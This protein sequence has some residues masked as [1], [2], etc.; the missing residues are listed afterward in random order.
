MSSLNYLHSNTTITI[1]N[2]ESER[3]DYKEGLWFGHSSPDFS[4]NS[5]YLFQLLCLKSSSS[6]L[7]HL[8]NWWKP[9]KRFLSFLF[10][11]LNWRRTHREVGVYFLGFAR[12]AFTI[13]KWK[14]LTF[15][16]ML[17]TIWHRINRNP[18]Y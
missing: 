8:F 14:L 9:C 17:S 7:K 10:F 4:M 11:N 18:K 1:P 5:L 6:V 16:H 15:L 2:S 3:S 13:I 12:A